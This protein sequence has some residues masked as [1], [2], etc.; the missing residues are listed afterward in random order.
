MRFRTFLS[1]LAWLG[2][3]ST[4]LAQADVTVEN[5]RSYGHFIGD[6]LERQVSISVPRPYTLV[7]TELPKTG[8]STAWLELR[9]TQVHSSGGRYRIDLQYQIVNS[10]RE[11][12]VVMLPE[13][14]LR[15]AAA[16]NSIKKTID[17]WPIAL[18][19]LSTGGIRAGLEE[20]RPSHVP[21]QVDLS[22]FKLR[23]AIFGSIALLI[24]AYL[25]AARYGQFSL[26]RKRGPFASAHQAI[27][28]LARQ[29]VDEEN[30]RAALRAV[31][32]AFDETAQVRVFPDRVDEFM[33]R[34]P[35]FA[36]LRGA[37]ENFFAVSRGVFFESGADARPREW[38]WL[39]DLCEQFSVRERHMRQA[40]AASSRAGAA[41]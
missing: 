35:R 8:R 40:A 26:G 23:L 4:A 13:I 39:L 21:P 30:F 19:P 5:P 11:S 2:F 17:G 27:K 36:E 22:M 29:P 25:L 16:D 24:G 14:T 37:A 41:P 6:R 33:R 15:F 31:H 32:R 3:A 20:I 18:A 38:R 28:R 7:Q 9:S 34:N 1:A 10:P 12:R